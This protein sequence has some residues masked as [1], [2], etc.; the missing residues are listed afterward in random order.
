MEVVTPDTTTTETASKTTTEYA[1]IYVAATRQHVGKVRSFTV[2]PSSTWF[3]ALT[4]SQRL[5]LACLLAYCYSTFF[6]D[7]GVIGIT[8]W[9]IETICKGGL[10]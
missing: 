7:N 3:V 9:F 5:L 1:P 2:V 4:H 6:V 8:E 10:Y